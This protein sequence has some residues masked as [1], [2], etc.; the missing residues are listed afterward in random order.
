MFQIG[1]KV[2]HP[3]HGAGVID[4]IV[5]E[6]IK[7]K[8]QAYYVFRM[9]VNGLRR[10]AKLTPGCAPVT[11]PPRDGAGRAGGGKPPHYGIVQTR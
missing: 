9:P 1:D 11:A 4:S 10:G 7:G 3:M 8:T 6:R 2:V 5:D